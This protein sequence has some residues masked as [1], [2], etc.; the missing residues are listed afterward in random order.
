MDNRVNTHIPMAKYYYCYSLI[1]Q[2]IYYHF[3]LQNVK[4][5]DMKGKFDAKNKK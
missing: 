2:I 4:A 5:K 3:V 1:K